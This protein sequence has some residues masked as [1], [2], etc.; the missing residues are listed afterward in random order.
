M[1]REEVVG[2]LPCYVCGDVPADVAATVKQVLDDDPEL[3]ALAEQL[4]VLRG[5]CEEVLVEAPP[6]DW[7]TLGADFEVGADELAAPTALDQAPVASGSRFILLTVVLCI[8]VCVLAWMM[9]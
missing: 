9:L 7:G 4:G 3:A 8:A 6:M 5:D 1:T 2:L